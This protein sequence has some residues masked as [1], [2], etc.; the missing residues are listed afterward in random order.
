VT[1]TDGRIP[2][3]VGDEHSTVIGFHTGVW[4]KNLVAAD[5]KHGL[6]EFFS[7]VE[8]FHQEPTAPDMQC[9]SL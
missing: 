1:E 5:P 9:K 3:P 8:F 7:M 6:V 4:V 2:H